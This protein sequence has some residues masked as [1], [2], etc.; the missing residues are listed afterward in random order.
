M[1]NPARNRRLFA[2]GLWAAVLGAVLL[3]VTGRSK[4]TEPELTPLKQNEISGESLWK[5]FTADSDYR[6]YTSWPGYDGMRL[7]QAPHGPFHKI[8]I[9]R[10]LA[11]ALPLPAKTAPEG[12]I[13]VKE[14][15]TTEKVMTGYTVMAKVK[16]FAPDSGDWFWAKYDPQGKVQA[17]GAAKGC[18]AC[19]AGMKDNDY[20]IVYPLEAAI[21]KH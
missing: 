21:V 15:Y 6:T 7:G 4:K 11:K 10:T 9:N 8:F 16:G 20:I 18:I 5:R 12:S 19:H 2:I 1:K 14:S 3:A 17:A 13:V